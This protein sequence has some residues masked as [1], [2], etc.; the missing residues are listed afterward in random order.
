MKGRCGKTQSLW[1]DRLTTTY[2]SQC[3]E[4]HVVLPVYSNEMGDRGYNS[5]LYE[6]TPPR[7]NTPTNYF[8]PLVY[9]SKHYCICALSCWWYT[10]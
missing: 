9:P 3:S 10:I 4:V 6:A 1:Y 7:S 2:C 5:R 8:W